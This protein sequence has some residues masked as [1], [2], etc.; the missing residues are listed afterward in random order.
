MQYVTWSSSVNSLI[1]FSAAK[2][3]KKKQTLTVHNQT[4][5]TCLATIT[6]QQPH[7]NNHMSTSAVSC[8]KSILHWHAVWK[9][10][11]DNIW[12]R[13]VLAQ[14]SSLLWQTSLT[15]ELRRWSKRSYFPDLVN[16][17]LCYPLPAV[18][19][20]IFGRHSQSQGAQTETGH[21]KNTLS[22][23]R[24]VLACLPRRFSDILWHRTANWGWHVRAANILPCCKTT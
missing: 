2:H 22:A 4:N 19:E 20:Q 8:L 11:F 15:V 12:I 6:L 7:C 16:S 24:N 18:D 23:S 21:T 3:K 10:P 17:S 1:W 9:M 14:L 5:I 13:N